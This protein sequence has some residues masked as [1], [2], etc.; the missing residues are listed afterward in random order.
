LAS[1]LLCSAAFASGSALAGGDI[2]AVLSGA[3]THYGAAMSESKAWIAGSSG[4]TLTVEERQFF[5][6]ERPWGYILFGRNISEQ[7]QIADLV[8]TFRDVV[9]N[10]RAPV[11]IDQEG[12][13]VQRLRPPLAPNYPPGSA[14]GAL[15]GANREA[16]LR[17]AWL[18]SRLHAF[19]L[20]KLGIT[21]DCLP[22]LDVAADGMT[23]AIGSRAYSRDPATV[24][25]VGRA[26]A[27]GLL[28][29][30]I[31]PVIKHM[32]GHGRAVVDSHEELP[33]VDAPVEELVLRDFAPFKALNDL[34]MAMTGHIVFTAIDPDN[35]ATTSCKVIGDIIRGHIGFTGLLMSDDFSMH[36]LS[37][38]FGARADAI[39]GAGCDV[40]LHCNGDLDEMRVVAAQ[41]PVLAGDAKRRASRALADLRSPD[42][43]DEQALRA[44]FAAYFEAVA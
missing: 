39:L 21:V 36:A 19:D 26:A 44:E 3:E 11:F 8:A 4:L 43:S 6:D 34:P 5:S 18:L 9:G 7:A 24:A 20:R 41:T 10:P 29:G 37:G 2:P 28:A 14:L 17:A 30:G 15:Y 35:P 31:L 25:A 13:R 42:G 27:Q 23:A 22:V 1:L 12:G 32:P 33:H 16:G 38:D 40:I